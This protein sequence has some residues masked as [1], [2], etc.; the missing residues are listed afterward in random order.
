MIKN[1]EVLLRERKRHT[2]R[3]V[4]STPSAGLPPKGAGYPNPVLTGGYT[5][6]FLAGG[7]YPHPVLVGGGGNP[8]PNLAGLPPVWDWSLAGI[9][10][11]PIWVWDLARV[12]SSHIWNW[13]LNGVT[14]LPPSNC[15]KTDTCQIT[16]FPC[17]SNAGGNK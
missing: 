11:P 14:P 3:R 10:P 12:P 6:P 13:D 5:H 8:N 17:T 15:G 16:F 1:K 7:G 9:P 2:A 4:A